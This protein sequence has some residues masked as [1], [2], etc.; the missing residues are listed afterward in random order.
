[1]VLLQLGLFLV[2]PGLLALWADNRFASRR[3]ANLTALA[4]MVVS[5]MVLCSLLGPIADWLNGAASRGTSVE[6]IV[7]VTC[8][9]L[10]YA[11]L[12]GLW[13]VRLGVD[14]M[15]TLNGR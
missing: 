13:L 10:G 9:V 2:G 14:A 7:G 8:G 1:M 5:A 12:S 11:F 15:S 6:L 3:P 4:V